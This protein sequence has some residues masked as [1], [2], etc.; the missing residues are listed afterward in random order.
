LQG[1]LDSAEAKYGKA[2]P[3]AK[4]ADDSLGIRLNFGALLHAIKEDTLAAEMIAEALGDGN[5]LPRVER[6]LGVQFNEIDI[7]KAGAEQLQGVSAFSMKKLVMM[8]SESKQKKK[9]QKPKKEKTKSAGQKGA[10]LAKDEIKN[11]FFWA[12]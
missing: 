10:P 9:G 2:L 7:G 11:V 6:L 12:Q 8:A 3:L 4:T 1:R 5:D